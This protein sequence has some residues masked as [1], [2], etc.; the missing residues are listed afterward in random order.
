MITK[1]RTR[2]FLLIMWRSVLF[3]TGLILFLDG[4]VLLL[5][6]K[7][8]LGIVIPFM[9]G[10]I[11]CSYAV[12]YAWFKRHLQQRPRLR[13][14]WYAA[15]AIF[16]IWLLSFILFAAIL[17]HHIQH[18]T[19]ASKVEAI[20]VLGSGTKHGKP[21]PA[22][23]KR[24]DSAA[25]VAT[26]HPKAIMVLS[27]GVDFGAHESE[28][29]IMARYL[30]TRYDLTSTRML[31]EDRSTSTQLNLQHSKTLLEQ[32]RIDISQP[33]IIVT[34]DFHTLRA[35]AIARKEGYA[36]PVMVA[37]PT[38]L[39]IRYNAWL[40]EYFAFLSGWILNEY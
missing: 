33:V 13:K 23:A 19:T 22:L 32:R 36:Q 8:H 7:I 27:G 21:S 11:L 4:L 28:A 12:F 5:S 10:V 29:A 9:I 15:W 39:S 26:Q 34:S 6:G 25:A 16:A 38:P 40:R 30:Q 24:L 18:Q 3:I 2:P 1:T 20:I 17:N 37:A 31:L 35:A 14:S